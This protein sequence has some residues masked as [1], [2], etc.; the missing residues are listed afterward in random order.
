[1]ML[2]LFLCVLF[3]ERNQWKRGL[4]RHVVPP[5]ARRWLLE[6]SNVPTRRGAE[7]LVPDVGYMDVTNAA[8]AGQEPNE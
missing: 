4:S 6:R 3:I 1:M 5:A 8:N 7:T 2:T